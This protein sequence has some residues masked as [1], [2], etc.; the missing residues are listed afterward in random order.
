VPLPQL[1]SNLYQSGVFGENEDSGEEIINVLYELVNED[2][3]R[4]VLV[5]PKGGPGDG[6]NFLTYF[7]CAEV[8]DEDPPWDIA[9]VDW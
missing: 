3:N 8:A 1:L 2:S 6:K 7:F 4:S 5:H 9:E